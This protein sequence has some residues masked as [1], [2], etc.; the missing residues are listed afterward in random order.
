MQ[1]E[2][3]GM[4]NEEMFSTILSHVDKLESNM[5]MELFL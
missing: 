4:T 2:I 1:R 5:E 3:T